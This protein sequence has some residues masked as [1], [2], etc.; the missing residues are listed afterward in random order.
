MSWLNMKFSELEKS[1]IQGVAIALKKELTVESQ[2]NKDLALFI[3]YPPFVEALNTACNKEMDGP[4][5]IAN[6]GYWYFESPLG[7]WFHFSKSNAHKI[8]GE[9]LTLIGKIPPDSKTTDANPT[10]EPL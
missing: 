8:L 1:R 10:D 2:D 5:E 7:E 4:C 3:K 6:M 9:F